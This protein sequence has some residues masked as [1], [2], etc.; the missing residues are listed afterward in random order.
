MYLKDIW[1][2]EFASK[3]DTLISNEGAGGNV[4][5]F[6]SSVLIISGSGGPLISTAAGM[7]SVKYTSMGLLSGMSGVIFG[8]GR[9]I[10]VLFLPHICT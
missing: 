8:S 9:A 6:G 1:E 10:P 7:N 4:G 3:L 5:R 2:K